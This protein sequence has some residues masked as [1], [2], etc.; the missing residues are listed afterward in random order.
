VSKSAAN[1]GG[2][3]AADYVH[4]HNHTQ[5]SLLD[6]LTKI[7]ELV[8]FAK[9][10]G[11][12]AVAMTD[13]GTLS[14]AVEFYKE[15]KAQGVK[16]IIGIETYVAAR[17]HTDKDPAKDK[18]RYHLILLAT[19]EAGWHNL[20]KLSTEA[21]LHGMYYF[22]RVDHELLEKYNEGIIA[23][24]ACLGG[25]IGDALKNNQ[26]D[27]ARQIAEW[28]KSVFGDRYYLEIQDHGHPNAPSHN[29]EQKLVN[30]Q[31]LKLGKELGIPV[32]LTCDAHYLKH[33]DQDAHEILLCVGTGAFLS[34]E[35]RMS[36]KEFELHV[37]PPA[38]LIGRWGKDHPEVI[39]NTAAIAERCN[40]ELDLGKILIP[41]FPVPESQTE[42][43]YLDQLVWRGLAWRYGNAPY[44][45]R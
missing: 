31:V 37:I 14:G 3:T 17:K 40:L 27:Q 8:A 4:L 29:A 15:C 16:P 1:H 21:N 24:S 32:A 19:N 44:D 43:S 45:N 28:Y 33:A 35:K 22:P 41:K 30:D 9:E 11:M 42:K 38:E 13:H 25:E 26:Y 7:P 39:T 6:G 34:D 18:Q 36:L 20:M 23:L 10:Q 12:P 5:F 2:L